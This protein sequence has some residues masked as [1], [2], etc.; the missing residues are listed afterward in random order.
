MQQIIQ[1]D[2]D[3]DLPSIRSHLDAAELSHVVL[4]VPRGTRALESDSG[5]QMLRRAAEDTGT[6]VALVTR[7][8][9]AR[10]RAARYGFPLFDSVAQ[11]QMTRWR[12]DA[13]GIE[14]SPGPPPP[15]LWASAANVRL[16]SGM[17]QIVTL[18]VVAVAL[19]FC[20]C[21][22]AIAFV[23]AA[24]VHI[25]AASAPLS[26]SIEVVAD[27]TI[28]Q[29]NATTRSIT[30]R[31]ITREI[32]GTAQ[33]KTTTEK[34]VPNA[35]STG[36]VFFSNLRAEQT[37]IPLGTIVKTSAG[38]PIR[39]STTATATLPA[40]INSRVEAPIQALDPGPVGNVKELAINQIEGALAISTRVIN[41]K[42][43]VSGSLKPVKVVTEDDRKKLQSQL[44]DQI[45][46]QG[47][48]LLQ[49]MLK[50]NEFL[51]ADSVIIDAS[52][53]IFDH[54]TDEP[55]DVLN[56]HINAVAIG[57]A[58]STDDADSLARSLLEKQL[59]PGYSLLDDGLRIQSLSGGKYEGTAF[60]FTL[61]ASGYGTPQ[62]DAGSLS[63]D[64]QGK[65]ADAAAAYITDTIPVAEPPDIRITPA[66]WNRM[67]WFNFRIAVF[68]EPQPVPAK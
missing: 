68:V 32:S 17:R 59:K 31:R 49:Q 22:A 20:L 61:A 5:L 44:L 43:T 40:G 2:A 26:A 33:L 63:R 18:V 34:S 41:T 3:D 35:P 65:S 55:A 16:P 15:S 36:T 9:D 10:E 1:L 39:F 28:A 21:L 50:E 23:P 11:A 60:R 45:K 57:L 38:I 56:L 47:T 62:V 66:G 25:V 4:V 58:A 29:M 27:P 12:M 30:A 13:V 19:T 8:L 64:L 24:N 42:P 48:I 14:D 54:A 46:R 67:P 52:D 53:S 7:D 6:E 51:P 37:L